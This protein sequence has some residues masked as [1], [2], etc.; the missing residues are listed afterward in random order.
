MP[1]SA[2]ELYVATL[3]SAVT[4]GWTQTHNLEMLRLVLYH[5]ATTTSC[6]LPT[7]TSKPR[8]DLINF[9]LWN[10]HCDFT[11]GQIV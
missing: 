6:K 1:K 10:K 2:K 9:F 11:A 7:F 4:N 8:V 5:C 3:S